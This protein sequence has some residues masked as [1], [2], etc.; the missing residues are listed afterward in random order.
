MALIACLSLP[1]PELGQPFH[2]PHL[3][4]RLP[5]HQLSALRAEAE[6]SLLHAVRVGDVAA[7]IAALRDGASVDIKGE[8]SAGLMG[9][10]G[11]ALGECGVEGG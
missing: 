3:P 10:D 6:V 1:E 5:L 4:P 8:V 7:C 9:G 2:A 11:L